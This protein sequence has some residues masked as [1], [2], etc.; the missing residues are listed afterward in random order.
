MTQWDWQ[1]GSFVGNDLKDISTTS[2]YMGLIKRYYTGGGYFV[3]RNVQSIKTSVFVRVKI[4]DPIYYDGE[5]TPKFFTI[6]DKGQSDEGFEIYG[7]NTVSGWISDWTLDW[8]MENGTINYLFDKLEN[9]RIVGEKGTVPVEL[10]EFKGYD[11]AEIPWIAHGLNG[12]AGENIFNFIADINEEGTRKEYNVTF[13]LYFKDTR[14]PVWDGLVNETISWGLST[15]IGVEVLHTEDTISGVG[16]LNNEYAWSNPLSRFE[17]TDGSL[18]W[19]FNSSD[20]EG[21]RRSVRM[22]IID[23]LD[24]IQTVVFFV[25]FE[26]IPPS[27]KMVSPNNGSFIRNDSV[28]VKGEVSDD[29]MMSQLTIGY[30]GRT[31]DITDTL[32]GSGKFT[33]EIEFGGYRG[34]VNIT[35][36][37]I[38]N[39]GLVTRSYIE[40]FVDGIPDMIPPSVSI[41][42][43]R[44]GS[45]FITGEEIEMEGYASDERELFSLMLRSPDGTQDLF[46]YV[47]V[48]LW[49]TKLDTKRGPWGYN[50]IT[51]SAV[52]A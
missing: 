30:L 6:N 36:E 28:I 4:Y 49:Q 12:Y 21:G 22:S 17:E 47:D 34:D 7:E 16:F 46:D 41:T 45:S 11:K 23:D 51:V 50:V 42:S 2:P 27:F 48:D 38:D 33:Y 8:D 44:D 35:L 14:A 26:E 52:D 9:P 24:N 15:E 37:A 19:S 43:P 29:V 5:F 32:D 20:T 40:I 10:I 39:V 31:L 13:S 25:T 1:L 3:M 18:T